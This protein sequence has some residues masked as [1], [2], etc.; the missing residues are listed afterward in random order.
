M[1]SCLNPHPCVRNKVLSLSLCLS[2]CSADY[3]N[4]YV[5]TGD[6]EG[7]QPHQRKK[8]DKGH[9]VTCHCH[10]TEICQL[11]DSGPNG[12]AKDKNNRVFVRQSGGGGRG[13]ERKSER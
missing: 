5:I 10:Q 12:L 7:R 3:W 9:L 13:E 1:H 8:M 6:L 11:C 2:V 4:T